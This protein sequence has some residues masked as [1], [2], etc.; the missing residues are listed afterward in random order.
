MV[1]DKCIDEAQG[2]F[3]LG[4]QITDNILI[5]YEILHS[6]KRRKTRSHRSFALKLDM[7]KAYDR[8]E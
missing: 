5:A 1:L 8:V 3:L 7:S 6:F 4:R 2:A